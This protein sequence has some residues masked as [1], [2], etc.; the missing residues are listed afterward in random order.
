[1]ISDKV[2]SMPG[3]VW[4][5]FEIIS[6]IILVLCSYPQDMFVSSLCP[7]DISYGTQLWYLV[8]YWCVKRKAAIYY[9]KCKNHKVL[10]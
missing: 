7:V 6:Q 2:A 9:Q 4:M 1:M 3:T 8:H 5:S 10:V